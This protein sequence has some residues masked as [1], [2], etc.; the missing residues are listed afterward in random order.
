MSTDKEK[1]DYSVI[2]LYPPREVSV[3]GPDGVRVIRRAKVVN[4]ER[5]IDRARRELI[6]RLVPLTLPN[7][8][9]VETIEG[10]F[11]VRV[12]EG[13]RYDYR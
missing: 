1:P 2:E 13:R 6:G 12:G 5:V 8:E 10:G 9:W 7:E 4:E 3:M 11:I